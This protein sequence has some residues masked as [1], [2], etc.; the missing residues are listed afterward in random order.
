MMKE[1][2]ADKYARLK[3]ELDEYKMAIAEQIY[4]G[5]GEYKQNN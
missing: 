3:N 1:L 2:L 5:C 4:P